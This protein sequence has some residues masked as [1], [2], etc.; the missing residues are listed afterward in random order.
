LVLLLAVTPLLAACRAETSSR[1]LWSGEKTVLETVIRKQSSRRW[2]R[3]TV[4][5][6]VIQKET[7]VATAPPP[8]P[9]ADPRQG[10]KLILAMPQPEIELDPN[11]TVLGNDYTIGMLIYATLYRTDENGE[12]QPYVAESYETDDA[13]TWTIHLRPDFKFRIAPSAGRRIFL[14]ECEPRSANS[15]CGWTLGL[16][17][18]QP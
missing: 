15:G 12:I 14:T 17:R 7:V 18:G 11:I 2:S 10:G 5:E 16:I 8:E 1:P 13:Q 9:T 3:R 6:T 4:V